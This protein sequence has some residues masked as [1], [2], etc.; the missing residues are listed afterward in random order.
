MAS[1]YAFPTTKESSNGMLQRDYF[2]ATALN[3]LLANPGTKLQDNDGVRAIAEF[4]YDIA[5]SMLLARDREEGTVQEFLDD[6]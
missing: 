6:K 4:A 5:D 1:K 2:A 3:G